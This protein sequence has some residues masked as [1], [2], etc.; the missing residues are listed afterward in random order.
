MYHTNKIIIVEGKY[1]KIKLSN[2]V[3]ANIIVCDGFHIYKNDQLKQ[4][5][6]KLAQKQGAVLLLDSDVA[7]FQIRSYLRNYLSGC[8]V[9]DVFIPDIYGKE[10]RKIKPSKEGKL[11]VEGVPADVLV[12]CMAVAGVFEDLIPP[13]DP[14]TKLDM[15]NF[16]LIGREDS[17]ALRKELISH[18]SLPENLPP[19][20]LL[21]VLN[22]IS[23][24]GEVEKITGLLL[25]KMR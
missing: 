20:S 9:I 8:E 13:E 25:T 12:H 15:F 22:Q 18:F 16:G 19:K 1:D 3:D 11:G 10:K 14:I 24:R 21:K 7:G 2:L 4:M 6:L 5:M 23:S 17:T